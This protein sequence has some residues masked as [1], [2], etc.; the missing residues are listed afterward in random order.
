MHTKP[1][2]AGLVA[3]A[4]LTLVSCSND[5]PLDSGSTGSEAAAQTVVI[6]TANFPESEIIGQIWAEALREEGFEVKVK[7]G[8]GSREVYLSALQDGSIAIVPEYSGNLTQFFG[9]L[10]EGADEKQ[11]RDTLA[12]V[13]PAELA[14]GEFSPAESKDAYRV[15]RATANEYG[16]TTIGDLDKL[17]M[18]TVAAPPEFA[19][20]PY[21][22]KGLTSAYGIDAAKISVNPISDGGGPLT[23]AALTQGK[24]D[25]ANIFTTSPALLD[26]GTPADL[27]ILDDPK[28]LI[29]PQNVLPVYRANEL[30]DGAIDV[31]NRVDA[32]LTTE[33]LVAMN[34]R[35][36]GEERAEPKTIAK[37]YVEGLK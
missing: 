8:I 36:M 7:S 15:T 1:L 17:K 13:L 16:L 32:K 20:R 33:D 6:G 3:L 12:S 9:E 25:A 28:H 35:N 10:P 4:T 5:D 34:M 19:E 24:A 18:I 37:D 22:P 26:D 29:P 23:V 14:A 30:P 2:A 21:G 31:I 11:V 27:V